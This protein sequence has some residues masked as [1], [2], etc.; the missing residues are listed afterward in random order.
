[1]N[2]ITAFRRVA[3]LSLSLAL[4]LPNGSAMAAS[5]ASAAPALKQPSGV[6]KLGQTVRGSFS[7][8]KAILT[9]GFAVEKAEV[10]QRRAASVAYMAADK[11]FKAWLNENP[12]MRTFYKG[13][14]AEAC[15]RQAKLMRNAEFVAGGAE[16]ALGVAFANPIVVGIGG[17]LVGS[18]I[19]DNSA[20]EGERTARTRTVE[21]GMNTIAAE[22]L[23]RWS[24]AG[25]IG[26]AR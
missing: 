5:A 6:R 12:S 21:M 25:I 26:L 13:A 17:L 15:V 22:R 14:R 16:V 20:R 1:M 8:A 19:Q 2:T 10:A 7:A 18:G 11:D 4:L 24:K 23:A 3:P 9:R